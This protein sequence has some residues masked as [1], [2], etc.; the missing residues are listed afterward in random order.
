MTVKPS[1]HVRRTF[2]DRESGQFTPEGQISMKSFF[3]RIY[4]LIF[5][6]SARFSKVDPSLAAF[7]SAHNEGFNDSLG[8]VH[9]FLRGTEGLRFLFVDRTALSSF[10]GAVRFF[11]GA[12][13]LARAGTIFLN[14]NFL[15]LGGARIKPEVRVVQLWHAEGVFKRFGFAVPQ[16]EELRRAEAAACSKLTHVVC[17]SKSVAPFYA[18]AF[19]V[20]E[21]L[22]HPL[23]SPRTDL[24]LSLDSAEARAELDSAYPA[25]SGKK[26]VLY[27]PTFRG[28]PEADSTL[29]SHFDFE[30]FERELGSDHALAVRL[31]PQIRSDFS[32]PEGVTDLT[33]H[34]D[35]TQ[36]IAAADA[37]VTDYSSICMDFA[38]LGK[39]TVFYA[40]DLAS[41]TAERNFY[42][43]YESYIPGRMAKTMPELIDALKAPFDSERSERFLRFNFDFT[44]GRS[45][46]R[47][48]KL[49]FPEYFSG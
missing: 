13:K 23:G 38:L 12:R 40:F 37:L 10:F 18:E 21:E 47:V 30:L 14:D 42:F 49:L 39:K 36:L 25:F 2:H 48:A 20:P 41:Y 46:E 44:D 7:I 35:V 17:S 26:L 33:D 8:A 27:A 34:P 45:A 6:L 31:H 32:I 29:L 16:P 15:P 9:A 43:D 5:N 28:D 19:G 3:Y 24:L 1:I 4:S 22:V 11:L